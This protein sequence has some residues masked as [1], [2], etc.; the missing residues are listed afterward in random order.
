MVQV[1]LPSI[2]ELVEALSAIGTLVSI[3]LS[4]LLVYLYRQQSHILEEQTELTKSNHKAL[5]RVQNYNLLS[6]R[7]LFYLQEE[8]GENLE[9]P[10]LSIRYG[11]FHCVIS[12]V[13]KGVAEDLR[14]E[15]VIQTP[16]DI[17]SA[18]T[19]LMYRTNMD[20][21]A[22]AEEG[23]VL[24]S[25]EGPVRMFGAIIWTRE[26]ILDKIEE[27]TVKIE[28]SLS[29]TELIWVLWD[30]GVPYVHT[31]IFIHYEDGTGNPEPIQLHTSRHELTQYHDM[32]DIYD[33]GD[34]P[35]EE[36]RSV[37]ASKASDS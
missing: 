11:F 18:T 21:L 32:K 13:G 22:Y 35:G 14:I 36:V 20:Q 30:L 7:D 33:M 15:M 27:T 31:A 24:A 8:M 37:Y 12:N 4:A 25:G 10:G 17:F 3:I 28:D 5:P 16:N 23:E 1:P 29:P 2:S 6:W 26:D 19:P 34:P 9:I